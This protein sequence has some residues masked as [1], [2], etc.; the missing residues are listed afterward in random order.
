MIEPVT[1]PAPGLS[2]ILEIAHLSNRFHIAFF[3]CALR[4]VARGALVCKA[5]PPVSV[6]RIE[7]VGPAFK[8][9]DEH[10]RVFKLDDGRYAFVVG[11]VSW[12]RRE[13]LPFDLPEGVKLYFRDDPSLSEQ[14]WAKQQWANCAD[15]LED[16]GNSGSADNMRGTWNTWP[17]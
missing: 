1:S 4:I 10:F 14:Q 3:L 8:T 7:E 2:R 12:N 11:N 9:T 16:S 5:T 6:S 15:A 13:F 17:W